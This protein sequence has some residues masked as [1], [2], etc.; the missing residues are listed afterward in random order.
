VL[1]A[2]FAVAIATASLAHHTGSPAAGGS[3]NPAANLP[4]P[5]AT[6]VA[7]LVARS[8]PNAGTFDTNASDFDV[9]ITAVG[10]A[11]LGAALTN[12]DAK[13]TV[14]A[15]TDGAFVRLA[16]DL[17]FT[18][19]D[20]SGAYTFIVTALTNLNGGDP[21]PLLSTILTYHVAPRR[22]SFARLQVFDAQNRSI[23]NL[24]NQTLRLQGVRLIDNDP[25]IA[26][27]RILV[28]RSNRN[29]GNGLVHTI[30]RV[31][32]PINVP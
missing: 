26:N 28:P 2:S 23:P 25:Q 20:E 11:N 18:G 12:P 31:L 7:D 3:S 14:F 13:L 6:V 30:D 24:A 4:P 15:P 5:P 1:I 22:F 16:R 8:G 19:T 21:I 10:A 17:G 9:L 27:A 29:T 32:L